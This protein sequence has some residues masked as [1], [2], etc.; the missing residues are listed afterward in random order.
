MSHRIESLQTELI[1]HHSSLQWKFFFFFFF[2]SFVVVFVIF[3]VHELVEFD[4][5]PCLLKKMYIKYMNT[6]D[7]L[8]QTPRD[9]TC[10]FYLDS[11]LR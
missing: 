10:W 1:E 3:S 6:I 8:S 11:S 9:Q 2:F 4:Q 5:Y 7:S